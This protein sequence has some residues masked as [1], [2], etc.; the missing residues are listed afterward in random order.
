MEIVNTQNVEIE[1]WMKGIE[2]LFPPCVE[3]DSSNRTVT[4]QGN[5]CY[6]ALISFHKDTHDFA[7]KQLSKCL[8]FMNS[9]N[10]KVMHSSQCP[11]YRFQLHSKFQYLQLLGLHKLLCRNL[12]NILSENIV[13][14]GCKYFNV[15]ILNNFFRGNSP[16]V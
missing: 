4:V 9:S 5:D 12:R 11:P 6:F 7:L 16:A 2:K 8:T 14:L 10:Y 13:T 1:L 3:L 15:R